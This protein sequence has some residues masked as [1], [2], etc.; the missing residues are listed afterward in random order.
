MS[1]HPAAVQVA[2]TVSKSRVDAAEA[3]A[4]AK[5]DAV[6]FMATSQTSATRYAA[7]TMKEAQ[8]NVAITREAAADMR[9]QLQMKFEHEKLAKTHE[10]EMQVAQLRSETDSKK[11]TADMRSSMMKEARELAV[12]MR[13]ADASLTMQ[14]ALAAAKAELQ[15]MAG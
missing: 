13:R 1:S 12:E 2:E 15:D 7:E 5:G 9:Q 8:L 3:S 6:R 10:H 11:V 4:K 14:Q